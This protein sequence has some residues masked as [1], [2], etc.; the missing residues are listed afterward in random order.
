[1]SN[2]ATLER[3]SKH[4]KMRA[5]PSFEHGTGYSPELL[6][7]RAARELWALLRLPRYDR[8]MAD[9]IQEVTARA[10]RCWQAQPRWRSRWS[11]AGQAGN[12]TPLL[13]FFRHWTAAAATRRGISLPPGVL[14]VMLSVCEP[15]HPTL[16]LSNAP[17]TSATRNRTALPILK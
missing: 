15:A 10:E 14:K 9:I 16:I 8:A 7:D 13:M 1:M 4:T 6:A 5:R 11:C 2:T 3:P 17:A 12:A